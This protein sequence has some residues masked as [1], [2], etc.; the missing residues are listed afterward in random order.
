[1]Q[2]R[3]RDH[4]GAC[5]GVVVLSQL[6]TDPIGSVYREP[7][8]AKQMKQHRLSSSSTSTSPSFDIFVTFSIAIMVLLR[9]PYIEGPS[10][11]GA[12]TSAYE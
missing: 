1:M 11:W 8:K 6:Q 12:K 10:V 5:G 2:S 3:P 7:N 4:F 9:W